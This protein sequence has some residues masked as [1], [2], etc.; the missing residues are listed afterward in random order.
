[1]PSQEE[2][3]LELFTDFLESNQAT[4][5]KIKY[6]IWAINPPSRIISTKIKTQ[7]FKYKYTY[8]LLEYWSEWE[9][10]YAAIKRHK[11]GL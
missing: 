9:M 2:T 3:K 5:I 11:W 10:Y 1:M 4:S 6:T 7:V 8:T